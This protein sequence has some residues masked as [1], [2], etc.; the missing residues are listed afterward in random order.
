MILSLRSSEG[1]QWMPIFPSS[2][3]W[4]SN[5]RKD[6]SSIR[7]IQQHR[8]GKARRLI[9]TVPPIHH[10]KSVDP[11]IK[12]KPKEN[13]EFWNTFTLP[14]PAKNSV[15]RKILE[16][17]AMESLGWK[18]IHIITAGQRIAL[19]VKPNLKS[20]YYH[21]FLETLKSF[22]REREIGKS[23]QVLRIL[24]IFDREALRLGKRV[25]SRKARGQDT[26]RT[27]ISP[28]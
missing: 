21:I 13:L 19:W 10:I 20:R 16:T 18:R 4:R 6:G 17:K 26:M 14:N 9:F 8:D 11:I 5:W 22:S 23:Q 1:T 7:A 12:Q 15:R 28:E 24:H 2:E 3:H 27:V 25:T